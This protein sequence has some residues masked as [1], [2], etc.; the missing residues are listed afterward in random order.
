[1]N[2]SIRSGQNA[3]QNQIR[4]AFL[5]NCDYVNYQEL[6]DYQDFVYNILADN[7]TIYVVTTEKGICMIQFEKLGTIPRFDI[8][9]FN[10]YFQ[11]T[12]IPT[13]FLTAETVDQITAFHRLGLDWFKAFPELGFVSD[14]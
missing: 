3:P 2:S 5:L 11:K 10:A 9:K 12:N 8:Q 14:N 4:A 1:M 13:L 7:P 6:P